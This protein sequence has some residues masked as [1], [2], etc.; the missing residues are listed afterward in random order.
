MCPIAL[1]IFFMSTRSLAPFIEFK[2]AKLQSNFFRCRTFRG[3]KYLAASWVQL[4]KFG[5]FH[6]LTIDLALPPARRVLDLLLLVVIDL[7][8]L[9]PRELLPR[10]QLL[11]CWL[12]HMQNR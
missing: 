1:T 2:R 3:Q 12:G 4:V 9:V 5:L 7:L 8:L 6:I 11:L 10:K